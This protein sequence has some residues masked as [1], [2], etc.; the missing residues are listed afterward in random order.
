MKSLKFIFVLAF[1][2]IHSAYAVNLKNLVGKYEGVT[3][4]SYLFFGNKPC[5][6]SIE[7]G[8]HGEFSTEFKHPDLEDGAIKKLVVIEDMIDKQD[9]GVFK[10]M[11]GTNLHNL[12]LY[13]ATDD[14]ENELDTAAYK[15]QAILREETPEYICQNLN[16]I[17]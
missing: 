12:E 11:S 15:E 13:I 17:K 6:F 7:V 4:R 8:E 9:T 5:S 1:V 3:P 16:K 10:F 2:T 14:S